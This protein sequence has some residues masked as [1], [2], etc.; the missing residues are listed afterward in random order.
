MRLSVPS[1]ATRIKASG[2]RPENESSEN[3]LPKRAVTE[4][5]HRERS[6]P[7]RPAWSMPKR[8]TGVLAD[9]FASPGRNGMPQ[10]WW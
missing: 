9:E 2:T 7:N 4:S 3:Q 6:V 10:L 5:S 1:A 8:P